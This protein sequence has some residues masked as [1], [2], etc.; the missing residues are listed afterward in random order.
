MRIWVHNHSRHHRYAR[1]RASGF[2]FALLDGGVIN[3]WVTVYT[4]LHQ[5]QDARSSQI[6]QVLIARPSDPGSPHTRRTAALPDGALRI[7]TDYSTPWF[8]VGRDEAYYENLL[9][10]DH[11]LRI[12]LLTSLIDIAFNPDVFRAALRHEAV[13]K[14]LLRHI[15]PRTVETQFHRLAHGG[16]RLTPYWFQY[17]P[18]DSNGP[19]DFKVRPDSTPP[20]N[21]HVLI[22][23]NG[24]G[25]TTLLNDIAQATIAASAPAGE[26]HNGRLE[27]LAVDTN[28]AGFTNIVSTTFSAFD[29]IQIVELPADADDVPD[30]SYVG[31]IGP[32]APGERA[33]RD[34]LAADF[35]RSAREIIFSG[36]AV[37]WLQT[38]A[39]LRSDP[40]FAQ[41]TE[42]LAQI[43]D[44]LPP[45]QGDDAVERALREQAL[46]IFTLLSSG[47][48]IVLLTLT[49][50]VEMVAEQS[51]VLLDEPEAHLHPPLLSSFIRALSALL[52]DRNGVAVIATHSPVVLQEVPKSCV[53]KLSRNG[54]HIRARRPRIETYGE[55]V[56][57]LT[58]EIFGLEVMES[59]FY[60][61]IEKAVE[62][63]GTY[64]E[65]LNH[66]DQQLGDEAK[67]LVRILLAEKEHE[68]S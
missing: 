2:E 55:N 13:H 45:L 12:E 1:S 44:E 46:H 54:P 16:L 7:P 26:Q 19:L 3:P 23:R 63:C 65:V 29:P 68:A 60:S 51:L 59:G 15:A 33:T 31:L 32:G 67:G 22:G 30:H 58:Q 56:G 57:V 43:V 53:H 14:G 61:E 18:A 28:S 39:M 66:F 24:V 52:T 11:P 4:L 9:K 25:K 6:G 40:H 10:L 42:V 17:T 47:H 5:P 62:E 34:D 20:T 37:R 21:I 64:E 27:H 41:T 49:R 38:L 8:S 35:A 50:L 48:A 36:K